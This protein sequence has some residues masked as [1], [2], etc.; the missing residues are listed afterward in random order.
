MS[1]RIPI[2][3]DLARE[4]EFT[5]GLPASEVRRRGDRRRTTRRVTAG[6]VTTALVAAAGFGLWQ[7]PLLDNMREPQWA[8]TAQPSVSPTTSETEQ[9]PTETPSPTPEPSVS[10]TPSEVPA[11]LTQPTWDNVPD[12]AIMYPYDSSVA[13]VSAEYEGMGQA[14]KGFCDP[15]E[16]GNPTTTL[17]REFT[18]VDGEVSMAIVLGYDTEEAAQAGYTLIEN[19]ARD[20]Q[21]ALSTPYVENFDAT[22]SWSAYISSLHDAPDNPDFR[23]FNETYVAYSG[24][25]VLW[26]VRSFLGQDLNC[27]VSADDVAGQCDWVKSSDDAIERL[28]R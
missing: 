28:N 26:E 19:A 27:S 1:E 6:V 25:R 13:S 7:S 23:W 3:D 22:T 20:C 5:R 16:W 2:L 21:G 9:A 12:L 11:T 10:V 24:N 15:G 17:V 8:A 18:A 14:A 4:A